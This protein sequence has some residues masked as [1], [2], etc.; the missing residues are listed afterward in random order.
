MLS[1]TVKLLIRVY[2]DKVTKMM[3]EVDRHQLRYDVLD[4]DVCD[5]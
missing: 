5:A 4:D 2:D 1:M 3:I